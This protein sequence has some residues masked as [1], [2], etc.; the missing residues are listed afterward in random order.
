[1][2]EKKEQKQVDP[3][4]GKALSPERVREIASELYSQNQALVARLRAAEE[5]LQRMSFDEMAF[6]INS[7]FRVL[8]FRDRFEGIDGGNEF[9]KWSATQVMLGITKSSP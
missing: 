4:A 8:E 2:E 6:F 5:Q 3:H 9:I 7:L 1:M